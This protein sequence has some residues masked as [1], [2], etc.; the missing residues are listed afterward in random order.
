M[1]MAQTAYQARP[2]Y[3]RI[4]AAA[5]R[6]TRRAETPLFQAF[7][8]PSCLK[9]TEGHCIKDTTTIEEAVA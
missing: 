3:R 2:A 9:T 6:H 1:A 4:S 5:A 7:L 8:R